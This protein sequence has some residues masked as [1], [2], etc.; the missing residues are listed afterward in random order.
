MLL[1][2]VLVSWYQYLFFFPVDYIKKLAWGFKVFMTVFVGSCL[3]YSG[4]IFSQEKKKKKV[5]PS[6]IQLSHSHSYF[7]D[8]PTYFALLNSHR[9]RW[10]TGMTAIRIWSHNDARTPR[11]QLTQRS[12]Q[13]RIQKGEMPLTLL[14][15]V[16]MLLTCRAR[17]SQTE[18]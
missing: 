11:A 9:S 12:L 10:H 8:C 3:S 13:A 17:E 1:L 7:K 5:K 4:A 15:C 2:L 16:Q 6:L 14:E 18:I